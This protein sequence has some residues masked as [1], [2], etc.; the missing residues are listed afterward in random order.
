MLPNKEFFNIFYGLIRSEECLKGRMRKQNKYESAKM[1]GRRGKEIA[2]E[3][4]R[5]GRGGG[6]ELIVITS[7]WRFFRYH[8]GHSSGV[9]NNRAISTL[10]QIIIYTFFRISLCQINIKTQ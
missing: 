1:N 3:G 5:S 9:P 7:R 10:L 2:N 6:V 8:T 4:K